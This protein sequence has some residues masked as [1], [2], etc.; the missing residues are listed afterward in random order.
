MQV[1]GIAGSGILSGIVS[2]GAGQDDSLALRSH[3]SVL[4]WGYNGE[5]ELGDGTTTNRLTPGQVLDVGG[6]G[7][8]TGVIGI[9]GGFGHTLALRPGGGV[10]AG[11]NNS[12]GSWGT[13]RPRAARRQCRSW[14]A[15]EPQR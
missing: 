9:G 3:G 7:V 11:G 6:S 1:E 13:A 12:S 5:G 4:A 8:L 10:V 2:V 14:A 15:A